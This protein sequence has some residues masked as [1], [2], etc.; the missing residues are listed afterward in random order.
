MTAETE[1]ICPQCSRTFSISETFCSFDGTRLIGEDPDEL[2]GSVVDGRFTTKGLLGKGGMGTVYLAEQHSMGREIALKVLKP[3]LSNNVEVVK[4]FLREARLASQLTSPHTISLYD[5]GRSEDGV[6]YI[7]MERLKGRTLRDVL[8]DEGAVEEARASR[9]AIQICESLGEAHEAGLVHRDIKPEN[10]F[11]LHPSTPREFVKVLDFGIAKSFS[12]PKQTSLTRTG[13]VCGTPDYMSPEHASGRGAEAASDVYSMGIV[14]YQMLSGDVPFDAES[15]MEVLVKHLHDIPPPLSGRMDGRPLSRGMDELVSQCLAKKPALRPTNAGRLLEALMAVDEARR[16]P[17]PPPAQPDADTAYVALA[18]EED[19]EIE[20]A[21]DAAL[22]AAFGSRRAR[23]YWGLAVVS[24][25]AALTV[26]LWGWLGGPSRPSPG[27]VGPPSTSEQARLVADA[28][29]AAAGTPDVVAAREDVV[30]TD[31]SIA[32]AAARPDVG[33]V[34]A[35]DAGARA[36]VGAVAKAA[37]P[38]VSKPK[39]PVKLAKVKPR[40]RVRKVKAPKPAPVKAKPRVVRPPTPP[41][42]LNRRV[43][44]SS[45]PGGAEVYVDGVLVGLSPMTVSVPKA[46]SALT[47]TRDGYRVHKARLA[48]DGPSSLDVTLQPTDETA[49]K[50][51]VQDGL[52]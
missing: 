16:A 49:Y 13:M 5:F 17:A 43:R 31:A 18:E 32:T 1:K 30:A 2:I 25:A 52:K 47:L 26:G 34:A 3:E 24:L 46:G 40:K 36:D 20:G 45:K 42:N 50:K 39:A 27:S 29:P 21:T 8:E 15:P 35:P 44:V 41:M 23:V 4:R 51:A 28:G 48:F 10:I 6:L 12:D 38:K 22:R 14:L 9:L 7:A 19:E 37:E 33:A 11:V